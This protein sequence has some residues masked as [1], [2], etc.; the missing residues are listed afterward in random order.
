MNPFGIGP[1]EDKVASAISEARACH[2]ELPETTCKQ[3]ACCCK[4][5]CPNMY[6]SEYLNMRTNLDA[7]APDESVDLLVKCV[8]QY[9]VGQTVEKD[10][11][12][13]INQKPCVFLGRDNNCQVYAVRPMKCRTYGLVPARLHD[14]AVDQVSKEMGVPKNEVPLCVQCPFVKVKPEHSHKFPDGK[15]PEDMIR[16]IEQRL[17]N[18]DNSL[19]ITKGIQNMG[20]SYLTFHDWHLMSELGEEWMATLTPIRQTKSE[21]WKDKFV[22]DLREALLQKAKQ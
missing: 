3:R 9:L 10:G 1:S 12:K 18:A 17:R 4:A 20:H 15:I 11:K 16:G 21:E 2:E 14:E 6:Y 7:M 8:R 19:G 5:G 13:S 22:Q